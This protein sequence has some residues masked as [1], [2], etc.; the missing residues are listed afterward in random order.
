MLGITV[1]LLIPNELP[2]S[3][4]FS[5]LLGHRDYGSRPDAGKSLDTFVLQLQNISFL[6]LKEEYVL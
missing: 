6:P 4:F 2:Y 1:F 3:L 5:S